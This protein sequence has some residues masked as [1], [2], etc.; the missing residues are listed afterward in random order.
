MRNAIIHI[1][2]KTVVLLSRYGDWTCG[3]SELMSVIVP[4]NSRTAES[5]YDWTK[6]V[7]LDKPITI[8]KHHEGVWKTIASP[9]ID[10]N[11]Y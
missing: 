5:C 2:Y 9:N 6:P 10:A 11:F 3:F 1:L 7:G 8:V 4:D